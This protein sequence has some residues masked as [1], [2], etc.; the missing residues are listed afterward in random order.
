M[1]ASQFPIF[2]TMVQFFNE[3]DWK[4]RQLEGK[5][6]LSMGF[7]GDNGGW[8]CYA[9]AK[10]DR[11]QF[12]FYSVMET[13]V[14]AD[15][16]QAVAE[17]LTRANYGLTLGNFEMDFTDGEVRYKTSVDV[18]GGQLTTQM[19]KTLVYVNVLMMDKYL[20]GIMSV[21]Y[22]GVPPADAIARIEQQ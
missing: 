16:R 1:T 17:F 14:P 10:D 12:V 15:K 3:D 22:A 20:P 8:M 5:P 6:I 2:D 7:K 18:E 19:V 9:Q 11:R 21:T 4:F 13:N